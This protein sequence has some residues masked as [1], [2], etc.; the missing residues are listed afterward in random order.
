MKVVEGAAR[1]LQIQ[2]IPVGVQGPDDYLG[3]FSVMGRERVG[4][5]LPL[6]V[7]Q[8]AIYRAQLAELAAAHKLPAIYPGPE[9]AEAGGLMAYGPD[10]LEMFQRAAVYVDKILRGAKPAD[11]PVEQPT[12]MEFVVNLK[13]AKQIDVTIPPAVLMDADRVIR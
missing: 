1:V 4:A 7:P 5:L 9:F 2:L 6:S 11:L 12:K 3:A 13:A 10:R 8:F